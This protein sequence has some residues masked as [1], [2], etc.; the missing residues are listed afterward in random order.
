MK[1]GDKVKVLSVYRG[2]APEGC[3][4]KIGVISNI[5]E[6]ENPGLRVLF[7]EDISDD[8]EWYFFESEL[9]LVEPEPA[10]KPIM[11]LHQIGDAEGNTDLDGRHMMPPVTLRDRFAM[12]ALTGIL[13]GA[14]GNDRAWLADTKDAFDYADKMLEARD[15][16]PPANRWDTEC[17]CCLMPKEHLKPCERCGVMP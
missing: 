15:P 10:H 16:E 2:S 12:A 17:P 3:V 5:D 4:G 1:V 7:S 11:A 8:R 14:R 6:R 13:A 9:E